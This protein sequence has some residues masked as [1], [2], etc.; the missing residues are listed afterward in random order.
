MLKAQKITPDFIAG[1]K[2]LGFSDISLSQISYLKINGVTP[3]YI[4]EMKQKG[5]ESKDLQKYVQLK[6]FNSETGSMPGQRRSP[7]QQTD[8]NNK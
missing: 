1:F 6:N 3:E 5:F 8:R 2:K 4:S 7:A